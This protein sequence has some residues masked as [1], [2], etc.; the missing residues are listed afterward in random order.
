MT[1]DLYLNNIIS[2]CRSLVD[3]H[4]LARIKYIKFVTGKFSKKTKE[5]AKKV[6]VLTKTPQ[7]HENTHNL[8]N[9]LSS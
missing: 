5:N 6:R 8:V 1:I 9:I 3:A 7:K 4:G 2:V